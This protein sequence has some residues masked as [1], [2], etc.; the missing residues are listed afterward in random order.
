MEVFAECTQVHPSRVVDLEGQ[1]GSWNPARVMM[2]RQARRASA[3]ARYE[4][5]HVLIQGWFGMPDDTRFRWWKQGNR[6]LVS[7]CYFPAPSLVIYCPCPERLRG[8]CDGVWQM[9]GAE[10]QRSSSEMSRGGG[11]ERE[12]EKHCPR[13]RKSGTLWSPSF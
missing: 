9:R 7:I 11:R 10:E 3:T 2:N 12:T 6:R 4:L 13:F 5:H 8:E 1:R